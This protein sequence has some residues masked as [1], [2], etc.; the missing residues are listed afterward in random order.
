VNLKSIDLGTAYLAKFQDPTQTPNG[1]ATSLVN[2]NPNQVR[3]YTGYGNITQNQPFGWRTYHGLLL[4]WTRR[5]R[6]GYSFGFT[7]TISLSDKQQSPARLQHNPDGTITLRSDQAQADALLGDNHPQA[8]L[9]RA[10]F[11]WQLPRITSEETALKTIG[12][13]VNNWNLAGIWSGAT[14]A[15]YS[16]TVNYVNG[17]GTTANVALTGSP[18]FAPRAVIVGNTGSG[19]SAD[20]NRQL[21]AAAFQGALVGS[22]GLDSGSG[23]LRGCFV[24]TLDLSISRV[25]ALGGSRSL[26]LRLDM[27]NALNQSGITAVNS[28]MNLAN[29]TAAAAGTITNLPYDASGNLIPSLT[30]PRSAGFGVATGYQI[31]RAVQV[32]IRFSF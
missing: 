17:G 16:V 2:T 25:I 13:V 4:S 26:Q 12:Y 1:V 3:Y 18:D 24:S 23:Y 31:P 29:T 8:H 27:F 20:P 22:V 7:D 28:T 10:N 11:V 15:P 6:N 21:N 9:M 30:L 19:C 14:G 5:M 32:Q